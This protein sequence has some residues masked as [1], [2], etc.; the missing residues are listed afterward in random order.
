MALQREKEEL[1][2]TTDRQTDRETDGA[3]VCSRSQ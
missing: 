1:I 3:A 2:F